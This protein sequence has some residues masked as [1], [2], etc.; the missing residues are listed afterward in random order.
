MTFAD[1]G[2]CSQPSRLQTG[3]TTKRRKRGYALNHVGAESGWN[4]GDFYVARVQRT[5]EEEISS[6]RDMPREYYY[7][8]QREYETL[9]P[10]QTWN[11]A[12]GHS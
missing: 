9:G 5:K 4:Y 3:Q 1:E 12:K 8:H 7:E 10:T 11:T 2:E 6:C